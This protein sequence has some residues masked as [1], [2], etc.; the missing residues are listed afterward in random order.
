MAVAAAGGR[1]HR[2]EYRIGRSDRFAQRCA[3]RQPPLLDI[4]AND[5]AQ[6]GLVDRNFTLH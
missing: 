1:A 6:T 3:E 2:D 4:G 5:F